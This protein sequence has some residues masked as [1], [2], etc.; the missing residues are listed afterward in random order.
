MRPSR[1]F[2]PPPPPPG[3]PP[4]PPP[5]GPLPLT[6]DAHHA[7]AAVLSTSS[8][9]SSSSAVRQ[10]GPAR[11]R[12]LPNAQLAARRRLDEVLRVS[13]GQRALAQREEKLDVVV[14]ALAGWEIGTE[15]ALLVL[16]L[17]QVGQGRVRPGGRRILTLETVGSRR[18]RVRGRL[19]H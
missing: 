2:M 19:R 5:P 7:T 18:L 11:G 17:G 1:M 6:N 16:E 4:P 14:D 13:H 10:L 9:A 3:P 8:P 12:L 15:L